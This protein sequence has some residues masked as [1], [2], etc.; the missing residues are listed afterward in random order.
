MRRVYFISGL[1]ADQSVF[2][3]LDLHPDIERCPLEWIAPKPDEQISAY[4]KRM[5]ANIE[6]PRSATLIGLSFGG[7]MAIEIGKIVPVEQIILI[8]SVK[9]REEMPINLNLI[10]LFNLHRLI[11]ASKLMHFKEVTAWFFGV[12]KGKEHDMF[13]D[14]LKKSDESLVDWSTDQIVRWQGEHNLDNILHIHGSADTVFPLRNVNPDQVV[15]GGPHFMVYTHAKEV[16]DWLNLVI[17]R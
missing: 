12:R 10:G 8:S 7:V 17:L 9:R 15:M 5:A 4:A 1:G 2:S 14:V 6:Y 3:R 16:S 11:P 13:I